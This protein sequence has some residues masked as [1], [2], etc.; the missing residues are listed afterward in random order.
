MSIPLHLSPSSGFCIKSATLQPASISIRNETVQVQK[1]L[2]VFINIAWD[3]SVPPPPEASE[4]SIQRAL[5][6]QGDGESNPD[7]WFVPV[8]VSEGRKDTDKG[9]LQPL[10]PQESEQTTYGYV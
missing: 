10:P 1:G 9:V 2:K 4:D 6:G 7:A 8:V 5:Q 3:S